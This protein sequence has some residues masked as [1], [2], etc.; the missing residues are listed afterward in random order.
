ML[1]VAELLGEGAQVQ[2]HALGFRKAVLPLQRPAEPG[3]DLGPHQARRTRQA[4]RRVQVIE[5][6]GE[7]QILAEPGAVAEHRGHPFGI[8]DGTELGDGRLRQG[9]AAF[10]LAGPAGRVGGELEHAD[11]IQAERTGGFGHPIPELEHLLEHPQPL[12]IRQ[13][14]PSGARRPPRCRQRALVVLRAAPVQRGQNRKGAF[15]PG[16]RTG[17]QP[18]LQRGG[19][20]AMRL[21]ALSGSISSSTASRIS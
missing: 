2:G 13:G 1:L 20:G 7:Q 17:L 4:Q 8:I 3:E 16:P 10:R 6:P 5:L 18:G 21:S 9:Q 14:R 15:R 11:V 19:E 12:R